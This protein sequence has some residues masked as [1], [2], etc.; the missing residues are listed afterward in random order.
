MVEINKEQIEELNKWTLN[1]IYDFV[2]K[3][4]KNDNEILKLIK[5]QL[6]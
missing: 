1:L 4:G 5:K 6:K 3:L 2:S